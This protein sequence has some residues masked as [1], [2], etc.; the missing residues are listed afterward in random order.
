VIGRT[1]SHYR[2]TR[3]LGSGGMGVVYEAIDTK[4][5]RTIAL[6]FLPPESTRDPGAKARFVH[7]AKAASALD[8][9]NVCNIH[10]IDETDDGQLFLAMAR[11]EGETLQ[12]RIA[13]GPLP[14]DE[15]LEI[16]RQVAEGLT[17]AH[18]LEI[19]HRDVKPAN[20]FITAGGLVKILDFGVAKLAGLTQLTREGTT[21]G[22]LAYMAPEQLMGSSGDHRSDIWAL[23]VMIYEMVVGCLPFQ[24]EFQAALVYDIAHREL[25]LQEFRART[26]NRNQAGG[27][28]EAACSRA[29]VKDPE[30]RILSMAE[31]R[32]LL[33]ADNETAMNG[34]GFPYPLRLRPGARRYLLRVLIGML[35]SVTGWLVWHGIS[36]RH[37]AAPAIA[38]LPL[39][40]I[41]GNPGEDYFAKGITG[42]MIFNLGRIEGL[43]VISRTSVM[44][45]SESRKPLREIA[46]ELGVNLILEGTV[47]RTGDQVKITAQLIEASRDELIWAESYTRDMTN[48]LQLQDEV[49]LAISG[50]VFRNVSRKDMSAFAST[51]K[52]DPKA[53][54]LYLQALQL[55]DEIKFEDA[56]KLFEQAITI[57]PGFAKAYSKLAEIYVQMGH[58]GWGPR[59][60]Y[61][62]LAR[63][64]ADQALELDQKSVSTYYTLAGLAC[65]VD[66]DWRKAADYFDRIAAIQPGARPLALY[67]LYLNR[68][69]E[70][71]DAVREQLLN[72][73]LDNR[74][75][76]ELGYFLFYFR[77]WGEAEKHFELMIETWPD[78]LW[79]GL[80]W[81]KR[82]LAWVYCNQGRYQDAYDLYVETGVEL[83]FDDWIVRTWIRSGHED[84][85]RKFIEDRKSAMADGSPELNP[86]Q[87]AAGLAMCHFYLG[88]P[89]SLQVWLD[90]VESSA[91]DAGYADLAYDIGVLYTHLQRPA[92]AIRW[93]K[94]AGEARAPKMLSLLIDW[95]LDPLRQEP[96]YQ[97]L[98][99]LVGFPAR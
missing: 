27:L 70:C 93:L 48:I 42:E 92:D 12:D 4:L 17:E 23:G 19:A 25:D 57:D 81:A 87:T 97:D 35:V 8:H 36:N 58:W 85:V 2:I 14:L 90:E 72:S 63:E 29:L 22:T 13:R 73:P 59:D 7:E 1:V 15:A 44:Q 69:E 56:R 99:D 94:I 20:I 65:I 33:Q 78:A 11:Y 6:K 91:F 3:Q 24:G 45:Y 88:E 38:V 84:V 39:E 55:S 67:L 83:R 51:R 9:P 46:R 96:G 98:V 47:L 61:Y 86:V 32:S 75:S 5:D 52:V 30:S 34:N 41:S 77:E 64:S 60:E 54:D 43:R 79:N 26:D 66:W 53:Y 31:L 95:E 28:L 68:K 80:N 16:A 76:L 89:D 40:D 71:L 50:E 21:L 37:Q 10:E 49:A 18:A 74:K 62:R 82:E